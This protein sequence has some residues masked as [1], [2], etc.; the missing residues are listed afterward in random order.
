ME[1]ARAQAG[2]PGVF[3]TTQWSVV[4][5]AADSQ[6][7]ENA[8]ALERLCSGYWFPVYVFVRRKGFEE[9]TAKDLTQSFFARLVGKRAL[10]TVDPH[11]GRFRAF[12]LASLANFLANEWDR[13]KAQKR[14]GEFLFCSLDAAEAEERYRIQPADN[15]SPE[16]LFDRKWAE[17]IM[18]RVL[19]RLRR[20]CDSDGRGKRF[21]TLKGF[22]FG[23]SQLRSYKEAAVELGTTEQA[24]KGAVLRLRRRLGDLLREEV[25]E[26]VAS[27]EDLQEE[28]RHLLSVLAG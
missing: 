25:A 8:S 4:L 11:K 12:L 2:S 5:N 10:S 21:E 13:A 27:G 18:T 14:G 3:H 26:T 16:L 23:D 9:E 28:I 20:E 1:P 15:A 19:A 24:I 6:S 7:P 22:L 17:E